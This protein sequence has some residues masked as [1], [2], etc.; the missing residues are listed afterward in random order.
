MPSFNNITTALIVFLGCIII[1][2][3]HS[4]R[5]MSRENA[6]LKNQ[7]HEATIVKENIYKLRSAH[8]GGGGVIINLNVYDYK[9]NFLGTREIRYTNFAFV[10]SY[11]DKIKVFVGSGVNLDSDTYYF[12]KY[13]TLGGIR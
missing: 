4:I 11:K 8:T 1:F 3:S 12:D 9:T 2:F 10:S 13:I 6:Y 7:I 5:N